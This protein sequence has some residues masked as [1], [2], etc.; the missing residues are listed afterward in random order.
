MSSNGE[1]SNGLEDEQQEDRVYTQEEIQEMLIK[2]IEELEA[3]FPHQPHASAKGRKNNGR[4]K[5]KT[6]R[7]NEQ[8]KEI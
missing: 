5:R 8:R 4:S 6:K 3:L 2:R 7:P 1:N